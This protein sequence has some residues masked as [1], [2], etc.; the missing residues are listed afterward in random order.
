M[1]ITQFY[2]KQNY[3][4]YQNG[5]EDLITG[6]IGFAQHIDEIPEYAYI[7]DS[8]RVG[9]YITSSG[10]TIIK[11]W[12]LDDAGFGVAKLVFTTSTYDTFDHLE[13]L[14]EKTLEMNQ[15]G[16]IYS[17]RVVRYDAYA[18]VYTYLAGTPE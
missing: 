13:T 17:L 9:S 10:K 8:G 18:G 16:T 2:S 5:S 4:L 11:N 7:G 3:R 12:Q 1:S 14:Y 6:E 15:Y